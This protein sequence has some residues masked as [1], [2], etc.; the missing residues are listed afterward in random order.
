MA[1]KNFRS[2]SGGLETQAQSAK[3]RGCAGKSLKRDEYSFFKNE[4][5]RTRSEISDAGIEHLDERAPNMLW[6]EEM[7]RVMF[8]DFG[9]AQVT[10]R[11]KSLGRKP[12]SSKSSRQRMAMPYELVV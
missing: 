7:Q 11:R 9:R 1:P 5:D 3:A 4:I 6:N 8:I 10:R 12:H 2:W